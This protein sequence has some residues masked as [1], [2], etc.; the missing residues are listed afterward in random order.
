M[1]NS[2]G[3]APVY[4][5]FDALDECPNSSGIPSSRE[6]VLNLVQDLVDL[7]LPNLHICVTSRPE[8]DITSVLEP[9]HFNSISLHDEEGQQQDI[10]N[11]VKTIVHSD[12]QMRKWRVE[13]KELVIDVLSQ[14]ANG[15]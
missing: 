10:L 14:K 4:L 12:P 9:L 13:D 2:P 1:L 8:A 7:Q 15:M 11:Y 3:Q 5:V 6:N